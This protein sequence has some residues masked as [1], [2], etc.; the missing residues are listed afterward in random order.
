[1]FI[2]VN[3]ICCW[4]QLY[5]KKRLYNRDL[6]KKCFVHSRKMEFVKFV[7][8]VLI[9]DYSLYPLYVLVNSSNGIG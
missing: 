3:S 9:R 1:M 4:E 7:E 8:F 2:F 5:L 6:N